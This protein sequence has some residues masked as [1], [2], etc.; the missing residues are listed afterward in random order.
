MDFI[1]AERMEVNKN[2]NSQQ[3]GGQDDFVQEK[4][5]V[6]Y[7]TTGFFPHVFYF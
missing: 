4:G 6:F 5:D 1:Y 2:Q 7:S 3:E